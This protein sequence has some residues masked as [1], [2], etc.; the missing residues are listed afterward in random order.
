MRT[1]PLELRQLALEILG[2][3][4]AVKPAHSAYLKLR[5]ACKGGLD[6]AVKFKVNYHIVAALFAVDIVAHYRAFADTA[7]AENKHRVLLIKQ[8]RKRLHLPLTPD[9]IG[10][11]MRKMRYNKILFT[12]HLAQLFKQLCKLIGAFEPVA[13]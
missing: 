13:R 8:L 5:I 6:I 11:N 2:D 7:H 10:R 3:A 4:L 1:Y 12:K 9:K